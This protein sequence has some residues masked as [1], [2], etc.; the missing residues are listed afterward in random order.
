MHL[1]AD[2]QKFTLLISGRHHHRECWIVCGACSLA[3]SWKEIFRAR[4]CDSAHDSRYIWWISF[5]VSD[6][7]KYISGNPLLPREALAWEM[8]NSLCTCTNEVWSIFYFFQIAMHVLAF[9]LR[10]APFYLIYFENIK[11]ITT[12]SMSLNACVY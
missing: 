1:H 8:P 2:S 4:I 5:F 10:I 7:G 6:D 3:I 12:T 11:T 9:S